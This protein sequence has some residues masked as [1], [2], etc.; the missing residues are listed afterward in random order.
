MKSLKVSGPADRIRSRRSS[1]SDPATPGALVCPCAGWGL[2]SPRRSIARRSDQAHGEVEGGGGVGEAADGD[3]V[4]T[5]GS[6]GFDAV[7]GDAAG[8]FDED[9]APEAADDLGDGGV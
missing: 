8:Y 3:G 4:G 9:A 2:R 6:D 7:E 1:T 5:E